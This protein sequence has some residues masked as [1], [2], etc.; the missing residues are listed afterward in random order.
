MV[1][2]H[3]ITVLSC[4]VCGTESYNAISNQHKNIQSKLTLKI[5]IELFT[6]CRL[7]NQVVES[8]VIFQGLTGL[9]GFDGPPGLP[10]YP[11]FEGPPGPRGIPVR[12]VFITL[13]SF[14][15]CLI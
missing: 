13:P 10:G 15:L 2:L 4:L 9:R 12:F 1:G 11:G 8:S 5:L 3:Y 14:A 6:G 7:T